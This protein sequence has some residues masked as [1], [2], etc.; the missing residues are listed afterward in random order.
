MHPTHQTAPAAAG[1]HRSAAMRPA[2]F[3]SASMVG[4]ER[5]WA[6]EP[7]DEDAAAAAA[8]ASSAVSSTFAATSV[9][10][11]LARKTWGAAQGG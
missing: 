1:T 2:S 6:E 3:C 11:H 8:A 9:S 4:E 7:L 10:L 5:L